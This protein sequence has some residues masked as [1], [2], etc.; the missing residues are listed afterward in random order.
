MAE[1]VLFYEAISRAI[2]SGSQ[3]SKIDLFDSDDDEE[4][5]EQGRNQNNQKTQG[6]DCQFRD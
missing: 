4:A 6:M 5:D 3:N 2:L 1:T